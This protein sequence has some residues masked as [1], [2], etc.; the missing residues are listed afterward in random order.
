METPFLF[1]NPLT[2]VELLG[3]QAC[4]IAELRRHIKEIPESSLYYHTHRSLRQHVSRSPEPPNDFS[5]WVTKA[6][7]LAK[8]G[9][10]LA[11]LPFSTFRSVAEIRTAL[12]SP[13]HDFLLEGNGRRPE[14]PEG[15]EFH[16]LGGRTFLLS[17]GL[18]ART[19]AEFR[20]S[21]RRIPI[22]SVQ[23]HAFAPRLGIAPE[24]HGFASWFAAKGCDALARAIAKLDPYTMTLESLR[25]KIADLV[26]ADVKA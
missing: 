4:H 26:D 14:A 6:L 11:S 21:L 16:F 7:G 8:T 18:E 17:T 1:R 19:L 9:E 25:G 22:A 10:I 15:M 12:L 23:Y 2:L 24:H 5:F 13:L 20:E 3:R